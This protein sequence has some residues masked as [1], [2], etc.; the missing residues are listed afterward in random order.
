MLNYP[1]E[2]I[3]DSAAVSKGAPARER[4]EP[5]RVYTKELIPNWRNMSWLVPANF[6]TLS[7]RG[8]PGA[9]DERAVRTDFLRRLNANPARERRHSTCSQRGAFLCENEDNPLNFTMLGR[10]EVS[11][12][13]VVEVPSV[14]RL[15][16]E[17]TRWRW[18]WR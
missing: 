6:D 18:R 2:G 12:I 10:V 5:V 11:V 1:F 16:S 9:V 13:E 3:A 4:P 14:T 8:R 17:H 7:P 15:Q